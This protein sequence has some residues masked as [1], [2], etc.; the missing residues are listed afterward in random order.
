MADFSIVHFATHGLIDARY[1]AL[2]GLALSFFHQ[3][4]RPRDGFLRLRDIY[5]LR[6]RADLVVLS[7]CRT[8]LGKAV[9]GEGMVG[10]TRGFFHAGARAV[11]A[12]LWSVPDRAT[13]ELMARFYR[14]MAQDGLTPAAALRQAQHSMA[15]ERRW[16]DPHN[17]A[18]FVLL[19][20]WR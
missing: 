19:G 7:A 8:A 2:S 13:A 18:G 4:G 11:V 6:L 17:W 16:R 14:S 20:D 9:R 15:G 1:P 5:R 3:D 10:L 12:S